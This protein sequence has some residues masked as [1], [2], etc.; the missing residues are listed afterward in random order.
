MLLY[1]FFG[2]FLHDTKNRLNGFL[3]EWI[4]LNKFSDVLSDLTCAGFI[5][6]L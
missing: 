1:T 3:T 6:N 2:N 5:D 4:S